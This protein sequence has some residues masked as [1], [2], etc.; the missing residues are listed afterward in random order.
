MQHDKSN[1]KRTQEGQRQE[2]G[3]GR[4]E[5]T[6]R[7]LRRE[8]LAGHPIDQFARWFEEM[9]ARPEVGRPEPMCVSTVAPDGWPDSRMV[10]LKKADYEGFVFYTNL[11]SPKALALIALPRAALC[12][13]WDGMQRQV[14]VQGAVQRVAELEADEYWQTRP[15]E[16]QIAA[17]VS[18]QS[19]PVPGPEYF[20]RRVAELTKSFEGRPVPRPGYWSGFRVAPHR[21][22]FWQE[23]PARLHDRFVYVG[24]ERG[25]WEIR[26]LYP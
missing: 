4:R 19:S 9:K 18:E 7:R 11:H 12:F 21:V 10:L 24:D 8:E 13:H 15:R 25:A 26:Q 6:V 1:C 14:R 2:I 20:E 23:G 16:S 22:E 17:W 5:L 3:E